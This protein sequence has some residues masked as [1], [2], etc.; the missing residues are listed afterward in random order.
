L[1]RLSPLKILL[2]HRAAVIER[3]GHYKYNNKIGGRLWKIPFIDHIH[4]ISIKESLL[5]TGF[6]GE[7]GRYTPSYLLWLLKTFVE[8]D[9]ASLYKESII[10]RDNVRYEN[11][12]Y[13]RALSAKFQEEL[14]NLR[15]QTIEDME[16]LNEIFKE[17]QKN[18]TFSNLNYEN[19]N[20]QKDI[21]KYV[22]NHWD[23]IRNFRLPSIVVNRIISEVESSIAK[24]IQENINKIN[25]EAFVKYQE[26]EKKFIDIE[27]GNKLLAND[28]EYQN[29]KKRKLK[30]IKKEIE[31]SSIN[32]IDNLKAE[33]KKKRIKNLIIKEI[34]TRIMAN[35]IKFVMQVG[36]YTEADKDI[37]EYF[38]YKEKFLLPVFWRVFGPLFTSEKVQL[39]LTASVFY[40]VIDPLKLIRKV[41]FGD[42]FKFLLVSRLASSLR[43]TIAR[44]T[45]NEVFEE[46]QK[47]MELL[48]RELDSVARDWGVDV[49]SI[50]IE[51]VFL[52][53]PRFQSQLDDYRE[54]QL[55]GEK[56]ITERR[57][58]AEKLI[59]SGRAEAENI[60]VEAK[61][62]Q[63]IE[64]HRV[65]QDLRKAKVKFETRKIKAKEILKRFQMEAEIILAKLKG[66]LGELAHRRK[67]LDEGILR[68]KLIRSLPK[69]IE[70]I[71]NASKLILS[72]TDPNDQGNFAEL[73]FGIPI[74]EALNKIAEIA[75][76]NGE[77]DG[78]IEEL[79]EKIENLDIKLKKPIF[80]EKSEEIIDEVIENG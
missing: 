69:I 53:D 5:L 77:D 31:E 8:K 71:G 23:E 47:L 4:E 21:K 64:L 36:K 66:E 49:L 58:E 12:L 27:D 30:Q 17:I 70:R 50:A 42:N 7:T 25:D 46:R 72:S 14:S 10:I 33:S 29:E 68:L 54:M 13:A 40:K 65:R 80:E 16:N 44:L 41:G 28:I 57:V 20:I 19:L 9:E 61:A 45:L 3:F 38:K 51:E 22:D 76:K 60:V 11:D 18:K 67:T 63:D 52:E 37:P 26:E 24:E 59:T 39:N 1:K 75:L 78:K 55:W 73:I 43:A 48:R 56:R 6:F 62:N 15:F 35:K 2:P 74:I 34:E 79:L 32:Q